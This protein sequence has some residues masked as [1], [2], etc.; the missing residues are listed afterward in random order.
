M[1]EAKI[2]H[3]ADEKRLQDKASLL[4]IKLMENGITLVDTNLSF[5]Q[6]LSRVDQNIRNNIKRFQTRMNV[7]NKENMITSTDEIYSEIFTYIMDNMKGIR[8]V[9]FANDVN[10]NPS[11]DPNSMYLHM[12]LLDH[13]MLPREY[14]DPSCLTIELLHGKILE[15]VS[16]LP[17]LKVINVKEQNYKKLFEYRIAQGDLL[18]LLIPDT[19]SFLDS[20]L[21]DIA[22]MC[23][24]NE[25]KNVYIEYI[26]TE[27]FVRPV[28]GSMDKRPMANFTYYP[29]K[30]QNTP[31][32][33]PPPVYQTA[34]VVIHQKSIP[35]YGTGDVVVEFYERP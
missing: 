22:K 32:D 1:A 5:I 34:P 33:P 26:F 31:D 11:I 8:F 20:K 35:Y 15:V 7:Q 4:A 25:L 23:D 21:A 19:A 9:L 14:K 6:H 3:G 2:P 16:G 27:K 12:W 28:V 24:F 17:N 30:L 18:N 13:H 29:R 10:I